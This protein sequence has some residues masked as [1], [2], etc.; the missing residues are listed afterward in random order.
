MSYYQGWHILAYQRV[1]NSRHF[2]MF[3]FYIENP[4]L[5]YHDFLFWCILIVYLRRG[6]PILFFAFLHSLLMEIKC[7]ILLNIIVV[8]V[9]C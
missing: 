8:C 2:Q 4:T 9:G 5:P 3:L 1:W 7:Y 6:W